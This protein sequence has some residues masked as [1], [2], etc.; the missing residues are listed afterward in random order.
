MKKIAFLTILVGLVLTIV[1]TVTF[2]TKERVAKIGDMNISANKRHH[3]QWSP[4]VGIIVMGVGG[5][6]VLVSPKSKS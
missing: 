1:T 5:V 6:L 4:V 2:F 3:F